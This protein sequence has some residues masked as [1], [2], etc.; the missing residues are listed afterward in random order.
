MARRLAEQF[1]IPNNR[2]IY[3]TALIKILSRK[4]IRVGLYSVAELARQSRDTH[5]LLLD[6]RAN[7]LAQ[8]FLGYQINL[9][10]Q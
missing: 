5:C 10:A 2:V 4:L 9:T 8:S 3:Q 6:A 7:F 1:D